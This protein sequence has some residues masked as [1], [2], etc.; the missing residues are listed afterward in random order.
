QLDDIGS[1]ARADRID[2]H[3]RP[4]WRVTRVPAARPRLDD[5]CKRWD[6]VS[7]HRRRQSVRR[8]NYQFESAGSDAD[9]HQFAGND[10][11][12]SPQW[13]DYYPGGSRAAGFAVG[14][15]QRT[16]FQIEAEG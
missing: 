8:Y 15:T 16:G 10:A 5:R 4:R 12:T 9:I 13:G 14:R 7:G 2:C 1:P 6:D 3:G 11:I